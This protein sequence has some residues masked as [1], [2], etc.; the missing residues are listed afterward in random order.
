MRKSI[1]FLKIYLPPV[2]I[3][4][5]ISLASHL[6]GS[7]FPSGIPDFL[8]H[9]IEYGV[10]SFF[11]MRMFQ[12]RARLRIITAGLISLLLLAALDEFHQYFIPTRYFSLKDLFADLLGIMTGIG[13][14]VKLSV[15]RKMDALL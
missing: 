13:W 1:K 11:F 9:F 14:Y 2:L 5:L 7:R 15:K 8:P 6:P 4:G 10:L 3:Y 12:G